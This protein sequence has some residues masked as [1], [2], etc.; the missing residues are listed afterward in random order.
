M[1][2][3]NVVVLG[4]GYAGI[5]T[6]N[7]LKGALP[8]IYRIVLVEKQEFMYARIAALRAATSED[9]AEDALIPY[10]RLFASPDAGVVVKASVTQIKQHSV[11]ISTPHKLFGS[12][13]DFEYLVCQPARD[14]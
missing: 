2:K 6:I 5:A 10:D 8:R 1:S 12:E 14:V 4:G 11:V 9:I 13:I 7:K 3:K